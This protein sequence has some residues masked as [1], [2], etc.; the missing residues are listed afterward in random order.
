M[1]SSINIDFKGYGKIY[2][3]AMRNHQLLL[4]A[5]SIYAYFCTY[6]DSGYQAYLNADCAQ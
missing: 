4:M 6:A 1:Y 2:K 5:K 3:S